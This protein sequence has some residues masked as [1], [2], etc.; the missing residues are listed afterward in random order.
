MIRLGMVTGLL[1][2]VGTMTILA[3]NLIPKLDETLPAYGDNSALTSQTQEE[4]NQKSAGCVS[5]HHND[6]YEPIEPMHECAA[7]KLGCTNCHGGNTTYVLTARIAGAAKNSMQRR[8][9]LMFYRA[10]PS[11]GR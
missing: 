8:I 7:V 9:V 5:C 11:A 6:N 3:C 10:T 4:A 1:V 2:A